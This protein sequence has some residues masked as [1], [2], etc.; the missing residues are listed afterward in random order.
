[1]NSPASGCCADLPR[2]G[3]AWWAKVETKGPMF[4]YWFGPFVRR[5]HLG[6]QTAGL[7]SDLR[8]GSRRLSL[9]HDLLRSAPG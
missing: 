3:L 7:S 6:G 9:S 8:F 4:I 5:R 1:M 2:P